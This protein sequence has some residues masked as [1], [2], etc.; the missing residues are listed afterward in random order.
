MSFPRLHLLP[1]GPDRDAAFYRAAR[2]GEL[3]YSDVRTGGDAEWAANGLRDGLTYGNL[4]CD[5]D[6]QWAHEFL[7]NL[8]CD[9][10]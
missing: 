8:D 3:D 4:A 2:K 5:L 7:R 10:G 6:K 1:H 9:F